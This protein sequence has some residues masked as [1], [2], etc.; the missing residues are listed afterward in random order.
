MPPQPAD[1]QAPP[2]NTPTDVPVA[3]HPA[4]ILILVENL[5]VPAD[6]RVWQEAR[7]LTAAGHRVTVICPKT[8]QWHKTHEVIEDI[9]I[10]R[11][12]LPSARGLLAYP[13]EYGVALVAQTLLAWRVFLGGG[14]DVVQACNPPDLLFL[15]ALPFK[16][17]G[18]RF[19]FDHHD[20]APE[21]AQ[22]KFGHRPSLHRLS[23][24]FERATFRLADGVIATNAAFREIA[25]NRGGVAEADI[26][27]V[28]STPD[29]RLLLPT[30]PNPA[31]RNGRAHV[32]LYIGVM[33]N[34]DGVD[35]LLA[36]AAELVHELGR[37]DVQFVLAGDG[38]ERAALETLTERLRLRDHVTFLGYVTGL[39]LREALSTATIGICPDPKNGFNDHLTMNKVLEYMLYGLP[40]VA[41][42]L[43]VTQDIVGGA[44]VFV[45]G[46]DP[47]RMAVEIGRLLDDPE[48][49]R[50]M[51]ETGR[52]QIDADLDWSRQAARLIA[53]YDRVLDR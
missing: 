15:V 34:Q 53:A 14:F 36:A 30:A 41:F 17:F 13:V 27:I 19:V 4:R 1:A 11:H 37:Q 23:L 39:P 9:T 7:A 28:M 42:D 52:R 50:I 43:A 25:R 21:L 2:S 46:N 40:V 33:G 51:G 8:P 31:L 5:P 47:R 29:R 10:W 16:L 20:L 32:A 35:L 6:R 48:R 24:W 22:I 44:G 38:P 26:T 3:R 49:C 18:V 12:W 45:G